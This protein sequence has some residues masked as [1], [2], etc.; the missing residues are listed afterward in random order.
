MLSSSRR[1]VERSDLGIHHTGRDFCR[2][3]EESWHKSPDGG[4]DEAIQGNDRVRWLETVCQI[5][6]PYPALLGT[7]TTRIKGSRREDCG[8]GSFTREHSGRLYEKLNDSLESDPPPETREKLFHNAR[9]NAQTM[10]QE[11]IRK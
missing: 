9:S 8:G 1:S 6:K 10:A 5:H 7:S 3:S 4:S 2:D 11:R